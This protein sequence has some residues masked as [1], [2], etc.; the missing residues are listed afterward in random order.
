MTKY[1][2]LVE[3]ALSVPN[4]IPVTDKHTGHNYLPSYAE[5]LPD[6]CRSMLE[7]GVAKGS[8]ALMW[9]KFYGLGLDLYLIDLFKD[10]DHVTIPWCRSK[11]FVPKEGDQ[12]DIEFLGTIKKEFNVIIEDGSHNSNQQLISFKHHFVN[13]L[14]SGGLYCVEDLNCCKQKF[15]WSDFVTQFEDTIL[16]MLQE[17]NYSRLIRNTYFTTNESIMFQNLIDRVEIVNEEI[18]FIWKK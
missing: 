17:Y 12:S 3:A 8:S 18:A 13:N 2:R 15:Y 6:K 7:I 1:E 14:V 16:Y 10:P 11:N 5:F 9:Q 4:G